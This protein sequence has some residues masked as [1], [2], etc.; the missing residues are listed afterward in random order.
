L[1]VENRMTGGFKSWERNETNGVTRFVN[2][3]RIAYG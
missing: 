1:K 2:W 3:L